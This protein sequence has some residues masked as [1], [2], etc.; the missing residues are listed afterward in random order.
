MRLILALTASLVLVGCG[1]AQPTANAP[2]APPAKALTLQLDAPRTA[3]ATIKVSSTSVG[4]DGAIDKHVTSYGDNT[5]P[6]I[7]WTPVAGAGGYAVVIED[8]D[9]ASDAPFVHWAIWNIPPTA[10]GLPEAVKGGLKAEGPGDSIQGQNGVGDTGYYG[11]H[12]PAGTGTHHYHFEVFALDGLLKLTQ[13]A[14][15]G[16]LQ[17]A[18]KGHV[19]ASGELVG[20]FAA[21]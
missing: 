6:P 16:A 18:M 19:I 1:K 21:P 12:P 14:E 17:A 20:T 3:G 5:S 7:V 13:G 8:P 2:A 10:N 11:P 4:A 9:A 15:I